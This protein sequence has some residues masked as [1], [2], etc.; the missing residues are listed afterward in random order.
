MDSHRADYIR[1]SVEHATSH[2][3]ASHHSQQ[4]QSAAAGKWGRHTRTPTWNFMQ[5]SSQSNE[6]NDN[7]HH[8]I[9]EESI[10]VN[11]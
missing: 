10:T 6:N 3:A 2:A 7:R 1:V 11:F 5:R 4:T 8:E 9:V